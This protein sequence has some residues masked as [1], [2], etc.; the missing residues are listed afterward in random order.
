MRVESGCKNMIFAGTMDPC[1]QCQLFSIGA[2]NPEVNATFSA[3]LA[4]LLAKH[5]AVDNTRYYVN[6]FDIERHN[7]GWSGRTFA[8]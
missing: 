1:A 8:K 5:F 3:G 6:F 2:L 4:D 7:C